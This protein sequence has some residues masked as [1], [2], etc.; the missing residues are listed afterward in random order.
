M[1][2]ENNSI[3]IILKSSI[4]ISHHFYPMTIAQ[5]HNHQLCK[6]KHL[7]QKNVSIYVPDIEQIVEVP[8]RYISTQIVTEESERVV[9]EHYFGKRFDT[10]LD[11]L[12]ICLLEYD[13]FE[14]SEMIQTCELEAEEEILNNDQ[15]LDS[16]ELLTNKLNVIREVIVNSWNY[17][18]PVIKY[19]QV[20]DETELVMGQ[21]G[22]SFLEKIL[23]TH[24]LY[25]S[26]VLEILLQYL[27][28]DI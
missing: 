13:Y 12:E 24:T 25:D 18:E 3:F 11:L 5:I 17:N 23:E 9:L 16:C 10:G 22:L 1:S 15:I 21:L 2:V 4:A 14:I 20:R 7:L 26:N 8:T 28:P 27:T 6:L 19:K